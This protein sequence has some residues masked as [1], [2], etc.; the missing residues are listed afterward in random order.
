MR[1]HA[2]V[3]GLLAQERKMCTGKPTSQTVL[4]QLHTETRMRII[5]PCT[6]TDSAHS[7]SIYQ[8]DQ[9]VRRVDA[10]AHLVTKNLAA[11]VRGATRPPTPCFQGSAELTLPS[12]S[13]S[14]VGRMDEQTREQYRTETAGHFAFLACVQLVATLQH[15]K[16]I[17]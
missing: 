17:E 15:D 7:S 9:R 13:V 12:A 10:P 11:N 6:S 4:V 5:L 1:P 3:N 16:L 14:C 2:P 8:N